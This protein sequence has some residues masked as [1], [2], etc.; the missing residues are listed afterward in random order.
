MRDRKKKKEPVKK[1]VQVSDLETDEKGKDV[2][3][4]YSVKLEKV[5]ITNYQL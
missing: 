3:G 1:A 2:K 5:K 4:G